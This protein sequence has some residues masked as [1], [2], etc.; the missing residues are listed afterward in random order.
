MK[1][2]IPKTYILAH[3]DEIR[4][5]CINTMSYQLLKFMFFIV[6]FTSVWGLMGCG[7]S[8][9]NA[10]N[11][12][13]KRGYKI[14]VTTGMVADIVRHVAGNH[15][16]VVGL[17][18]EGVDPHLYT[19]NRNDTVH[20]MEADVIFYSGLHLEGHMQESFERHREAGK[21]VFAVTESLEKSFLRNPSEFEGYPDP[22]VWM[23]VTAWS[24][25]VAEVAKQLS[26]Y[27]KKHAAEYQQNAKEYRKELEQLDKYIKGIIKTIPK[28]QRV[29]VT[30]H[31]AF[32]YFG[33]AYQIS[34]RSVQGISTE[35]EPSLDDITSLVDFVVE[36]KVPAIFIESSVPQRS[37]QAI[38]EGVRKKGGDIALGGSLFSDAMG[39]TGTYEGTYIGMLDHNATLIVYALGGT[40][41]A[42]GFQKK[43]TLIP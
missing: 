3:N 40:A 19:P 26:M 30:A 36:Q 17:M 25:C 23:D 12:Q 43:L 9:Q 8:S 18:A 28:K 24:Q 38:Q 34:V 32:G 2:W 31:D 41:P 20:M 11:N 15:A 29:L 7:K 42:K 10:V 14:V 4:K 35:S 21:P 1:F 33:R 37:V 39:A 13:V 5:D 27:D 6:V 22:H 16:E